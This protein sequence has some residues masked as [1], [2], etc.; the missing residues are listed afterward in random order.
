VRYCEAQI[1][2][3]S[4]ISQDEHETKR[5]GTEHEK[6]QGR[7]ENHE[8]RNHS[9]ANKEVVNAEHDLK[10]TRNAKIAKEKKHKEE[11]PKSKSQYPSQKT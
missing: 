2:H 3:V 4:A 11:P 7:N 6:T 5:D 10:S 9:S 8:I 1:K